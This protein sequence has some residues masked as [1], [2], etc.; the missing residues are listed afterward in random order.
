MPEE[1]CTSFSRDL[2]GLDDDGGVG[3][4]DSGG[5]SLSVSMAFLFS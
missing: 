2:C 5:V 1:Y 4:G 3:D